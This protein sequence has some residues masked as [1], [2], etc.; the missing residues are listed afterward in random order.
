MKK[1]KIVKKIEP[2]EVVRRLLILNLIAQ[3]V[4]VKDIAKVLGVVESAITNIVP[5]RS[6]KESTKNR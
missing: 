4:L 5:V 1:R 2:D 3:G 6:I